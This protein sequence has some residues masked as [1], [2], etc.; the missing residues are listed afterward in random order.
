[1]RCEQQWR[2]FARAGEARDDVRAFGR[3]FEQLRRQA[4][5]IEFVG[6]D[7]CCRSFTTRRVRRIDAKQGLAEAN[8][9][10]RQFSVGT[11]FRGGLR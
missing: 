9:V 4:G 5:P 8:G 6:D 2:Q 11:C 1:M 3:A 7:V 10:I